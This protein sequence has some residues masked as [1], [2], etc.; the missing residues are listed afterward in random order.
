MWSENG[1]MARLLVPVV[2]AAAVAFGGC[3]GASPAGQG[4]S[5]VASSPAARLLVVTHTTGFRHDSIP[6]AEEALRQIGA[7][8]GLFTTEFCRTADDV[9]ARLTPAGLTGIDAVFFANTS[10]DLGIP[11]VQAFVDWV[12]SGKAFLGSHSASDTYH[13]SPAY[14]ALLG[15]EVVTHGGIVD[16]DVRVS[17]P[18]NPIVSHLAPTF[19]ISDEW[20][21]LQLAGPGRTVL[22]KFDRNPSD[23]VGSPGEAVDLPLTWQKSHGS[24]RVFYT[25]LGHRSETWEDAR[26]RRLLLEAI[27]WALGR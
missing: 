14:L 12:A 24:G 16:A 6:A 2:V 13:E 7:Q 18:G 19:R 27:R 4:P 22:L 20:Y 15:G 17:E 23:G 5:P 10:G 3:G 1:L 26:F 21:R 9:R 8:S 25:A 11:D